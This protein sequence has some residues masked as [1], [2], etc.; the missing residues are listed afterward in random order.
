MD[1]ALKA[2]KKL[3]KK[4]DSGSLK[5]KVLAKEVA[6]KIQDENASVDQVKKWIVGSDKF[7]VEKKLVSL[8]KSSKKKRDREEKSG[9]SKTKRAKKEKNDGNSSGDIS[10]SEASTWRTDNKVV[11]RATL[12]DKEGEADASKEL[13]NS[14]AYLPYKNFSSTR[15][16]ESIHEALLRQCTEVNGFKTPSAIQAQCWPVLLHPGSDGK[17]RD[18]V[19]IAETGSG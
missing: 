6:Q 19:G 4:N 10:V 16:K 12:D 8:K 9:E 17:R 14:E 7:C 15:C 5:L 11:L 3:L 2:A 18:V 13:N 1:A